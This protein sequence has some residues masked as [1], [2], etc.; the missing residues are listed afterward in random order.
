MGR[1]VSYKYL[2]NGKM[3]KIVQVKRGLRQGDPISLLFFILVME[4]LQRS[5]RTLKEVPDF[6]FHLK[7][8]KLGIKNVCFADDVLLFSRGD[9]VSIR[10][11]MQ[12]FRQFSDATGHEVN[13]AKCKIYFG[14]IAEHINQTIATEIRYGIGTLPFKYLG[15][16]LST[17]KL[18][19]NQCQPIIDR[20]LEKI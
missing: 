14:G 13:P 18:T 10:L 8:A 11:M 5:P 2:I 16:P 12:K 19:I 4:Y 20:M 9:E 17:R 7:Y 3:S 15:V 1:G 6:N